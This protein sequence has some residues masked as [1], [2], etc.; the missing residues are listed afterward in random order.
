MQP[1]DVGLP[2]GKRRHVAGLR[3]EEVAQLAGVGLD[4]YVLLEQGRVETVSRRSLVRVLAGLRLGPV[5]RE[6]AFA[7]ALARDDEMVRDA[8]AGEREALSAFVQAYR[9]GIAFA[10]DPRWQVFAWNEASDELF[11]FS[12]HA[13]GDRQ[14]L[15]LMVRDERMRRAFVDWNDALRRM[16]AVFRASPVAVAHELDDLV[17][18]LRAESDLFDR[19]WTAYR[20]GS[21]TTHTC[22]LRSADGVERTLQFFALAPVDSPEYTVVTLR[23]TSSESHGPL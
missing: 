15:A 13:D 8:S 12:A 5:E 2:A 11:A 14:M 20:V 4:W 6:H 10:T 7:L 16:I 21:P 17:A 1:G 23:P 3:R 18:A 22:L 9:S 19:L